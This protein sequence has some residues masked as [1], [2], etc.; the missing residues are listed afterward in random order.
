MKV[1][2]DESG[3]GMNVVLDEIY[4]FGM[5]SAKLDQTAPNQSGVSSAPAGSVQWGRGR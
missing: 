3:F 1:V 4:T 5:K 2:L